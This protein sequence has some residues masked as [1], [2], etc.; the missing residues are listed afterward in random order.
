M[1]KVIL[2][3]FFLISNLLSINAHAMEISNKPVIVFDFGGVIAQ[4]NTAKMVDFLTTTLNV[5]KDELSSALREMQSIVAGGGSEEQFW[6][7]YAFTKKI[8][9]PSDWF[10]KFG[11]IINSSI[12]PIPETIALVK[13]LQRGGYQTAMLSDVTQYQAEIIRKMGYYDLFDPVLLSYETGVKKPNPEAFKILIEKLQ[14]PSSLLIF[15]DD[16]IENVDAA[17]N[18]GIDAIHFLSPTQL[19][20]EFEKRGIE[21]D[22]TCSH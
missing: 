3:F 21:F 13:A 4:A 17:I 14:V 5:N 8:I 22:K 16:K 1:L 20:E 2:T 11:V 6:Q 12:S 18:Q 9:L 19:K 15:I 7:N 10:E